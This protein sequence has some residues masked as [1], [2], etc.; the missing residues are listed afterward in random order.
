M[1]KYKLECYG[2]EIEAIAKSLTEKQ[3]DNI[4]QLMADNDYDELYE[5]RHELDEIGID[6]YEAD[7]FHFTKPLYA[8]KLLFK[9]VTETD[10]E[11]FRFEVEDL[12]HIED[13]IDDYEGNAVFVAIPEAGGVERLLFCV[14]ENK[15]GLFYMEFE[16]DE[17]PTVQDFAYYG[18]CIEA[19]NSDWDF[20]EELFFKG[21]KLEI[22]DYLG[23]TG[24]AST[25]E[26]WTLD[27][28]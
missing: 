13:V 24:K 10:E 20:I 22:T 1:A 19:P 15:G 5:T 6:I 11:V 27:N 2:W 9:V 26:L 3:V 23:N 16:T 28:I 8:G 18:N 21:K 12:T 4:H 14:D 25:T 17:V 7:I